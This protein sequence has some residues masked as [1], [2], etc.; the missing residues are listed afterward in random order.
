MSQLAQIT[1]SAQFTW[2]DWL[3][4]V[5][6]LALTTWL[7]ARMAGRQA[8]IRDFFLGGRR[9]PWYAVSG[10]I[11]A[12]EI[13]AVTFISVPSVVFRPGGN[14]TYLQ[15]GVFGSFLARIFVGY[16]L[17][18]A[19]YRLEIYSPYDYMGNQLGGRVRTMTTVLFAFGGVLAQSARVYLTAEVVIVVLNDQ[20]VTL[21][22]HLGLDPLAWAIILIGVVS[23]GW[24]LIGGITTVIWTDVILFLVFLFGAVVALGTVAANLDGGVGEM[25]RVGWSAQESGSW[26]KFTFFDFS[27][28]PL[29]AYTIWTAAIASTWGG[30]GAYG[31]DQ[32]LAQRMFCC[33]GPREARWAIISSTAGLVVTFTVMLVGVGLYAYYQAN[34]LTGDA[35]ELYRGKV[36]RIFPIFIVQVIPFGL[37]GLIIAGVFAAAISSLMGILTALSQTVMSAFYLPFRE[38]QLKKRGMAASISRNRGELAEEGGGASAEDR[39]SVL[40]GRLMVL[41]WGVVLCCMAYLARYVAAKYPSILDLALALA[42]YAGGALLAGFALAFLP[43]KINGRGYMWS[44]PLSVLC[45]FALVWHQPWSHYVCWAA[46]AITITVWLWCLAR[47]RA[48]ARLTPARAVAPQL[49]VLPVGAQTFALAVGLALILL[50]NYHGHWG[51]GPQDAFGNP[52]YATIAWPWYAPIGSAVAFVFGYLLAERRRDPASSPSEGSTTEGSSHVRF[53]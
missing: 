51:V 50:L 26:G 24:T 7:G 2:I 22:N 45:V 32:L 20:L 25:L 53:N 8:S 4:V 40:V 3:V 1:V 47:E 38:R 46:A 37:K 23:V 13:S 9:L 19:Y 52:T 36:D 15:L 48:R 34:P 18:P 27:T 14:L 28:D 11:I 43:L 44:G 39:R 16:V 31:T 21:S 17:V 29:R 42:G 30:L 10:S 5:S 41:T 33:K 49:P 35:L 6:Y 12:T